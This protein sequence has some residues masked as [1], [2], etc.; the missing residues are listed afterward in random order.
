[1]ALKSSTP[2]F[3]VPVPSW[4]YAARTATDCK[5]GP[6]FSAA[7]VQPGL[8]SLEMSEGASGSLKVKASLA[9]FRKRR[10]HASSAP[11]MTDRGPR[12]PW[13]Y[14][15]KPAAERW[16]PSGWCGK[17]VRPCRWSRTFEIP[18][19]VEFPFFLGRSSFSW[20]GL[21][22]RQQRR[23]AVRRPKMR[24]RGAT[25]RHSRWKSMRRARAG[26]PT[27]CGSGLPVDDRS[28]TI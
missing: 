2:I 18:R 16:R 20:G 15:R 6:S 7:I 11:A 25:P 23:N 12:A 3:W 22:F 8:A 28:P 21:P 1:L 4:S 19:A 24:D 17:H 27:R 10:A 9:I 14:A 5:A 13:S 26:S